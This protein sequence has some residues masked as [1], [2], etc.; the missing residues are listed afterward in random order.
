M[1]SDG[2]Y[3][4][5]TILETQRKCYNDTTKLLFSSLNDIIEKQ[6][7]LIQEL[8]TSIEFSQQETSDL[9][10]E[11]KNVKSDLKEYKKKT[12]DQQ[13]SIINLENKL[14][15][16]EDH[17]RRKNIRIE[18]VEETSDENKEK[19]QYKIET[20]LKNKL[21]LPNV[22]ISNIHRVTPSNNLRRSNP[23]TILA[24]L[25]NE[26]DRD[27]TMRNTWRLKDTGIY[28]TEDV[29]ENS[30]RIRKEKLPELRAAKESGKIAYFSR[31]KLIIKNRNPRTTTNAEKQNDEKTPP[32]PRRSTRAPRGEHDE[33][34]KIDL[35]RNLPKSV[36][37]TGAE[38]EQKK[39]SKKSQKSSIK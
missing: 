19:L 27:L 17:S 32:P 3:D 7:C 26:G 16:Q 28:I 12:E 38:D 10:N 21:Q 30:A 2:K 36:I 4:L 14:N 29:C 22:K 23:R 18:G 24:R 6:N 9:K 11:L 15:S 25:V 39:N 37:G 20:V 31:S 8:K 1:S 35:T 13:M 33:N 34:Q 5:D